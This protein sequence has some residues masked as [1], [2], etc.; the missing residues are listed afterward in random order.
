MNTIIANINAIGP[1]LILIWSFVVLMSVIR[2]QRF[3]NCL[4][5]LAALLISVFFVAGLFGD[6]MGIAFLVMFFAGIL[7]LFAVPV[8]LI[9]NGVIMMKKERRSLSNM[10]SLALGVIVA[11]G[12]VSLIYS[13]LAFS[14]EKIQTTNFLFGFSFLFGC[15]VFYFCVLILGFV[16]YNIFIEHIPRRQ[17]FDYVIIHGC[18][19]IDGEKTSR[20]LEGRLDAA[21]K[22][23]EN[24]KVK[25]VIMPSGGQGPD[26]KIS[27]A[28]A[29]KNYLLEKGVPEE[30]IILE[31]KSGTTMENLKNC[32]ALIGPDHGR[33]ALVSSNYHVY[34]CLLYARKIGLKCTGIGGKVAPY[35]WPS[36]LLREFAA[37]FTMPRN[38]IF[39]IIGYLFCMSLPAL[40]IFGR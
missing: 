7:A 39:I 19:L 21:I 40:L 34:R 2:P 31:D 16:L 13:V 28:Q 9:R 32:Q 22:I 18:G 6:Y 27:E 5:L 20:L 37:V 33:I 10:L 11:L 38:L 35:Y 17:A 23:Y 12:E 1:K 24:C 30:R 36:A 3:R 8:M 29:M 4:Y 15:T 14:F 25:P 26:E